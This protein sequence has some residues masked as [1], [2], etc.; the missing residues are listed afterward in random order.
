MRKYTSARAKRW[1][2]PSIEF[3]RGRSKSFRKCLLNPCVLLCSR[4][5]PPHPPSLPPSLPSHCFSSSLY[6]QECTFLYFPLCSCLS[7][8]IFHLEDTMGSW[9]IYVSWETVLNIHWWLKMCFC[10]ITAVFCYRHKC[11]WQL[12]QSQMVR[13]YKVVGMDPQNMCEIK[14]I[15]KEIPL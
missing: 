1:R 2:L 5:F 15:V 6:K 4:G 9:N 12:Q 7:S 10:Y 8:L 11:E 3:F 13:F 14:V